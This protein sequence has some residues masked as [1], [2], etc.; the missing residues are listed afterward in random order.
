MA[1]PDTPRP[2]RDDTVFRNKIAE[3]REALLKPAIGHWG[4]LK[5]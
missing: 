3:M 1:D 4:Q 2:V 5:E